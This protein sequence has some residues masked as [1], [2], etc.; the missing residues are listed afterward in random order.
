MLRDEANPAGDLG[1]ITRI[2]NGEP[3]DA[4]RAIYQELR[5]VA[6]GILRRRGQAPR[7]I[8]DIGLTTVV[9][10]AWLKLSRTQSWDSRAHFFGS[11][12][13]AVRQILADFAAQRRGT[14]S[15][16]GEPP[17]PTGEGAGEGAGEG[18]GERPDAIDFA[19]RV[20]EALLDL[21]A[22]NPRCG[23]IAE[24]KLFGDLSVPMISSLV[25]VSERTVAREWRFARVWLAQRLGDDVP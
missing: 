25:G 6:G 1:T 20:H 11:A 13:R 23:R 14:Q 24:L 21:E 22:V 16:L 10:E 9:H 8:A 19:R 12:A 4:Y 18:R 17:E 7:T 15:L 5:A 2:V 3:D